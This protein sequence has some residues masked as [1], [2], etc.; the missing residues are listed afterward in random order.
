MQTP[1]KLDVQMRNVGKRATHLLRRRKMVPAI[2]YGHIPNHPIALEERLLIKYSD[3]K[4]ENM[5]FHL[6]CSTNSELHNIPVLIKSTER[7]PVTRKPLHLDFY[8]PD[9]TKD[10]CVTVKLKFV[11]KA[12][13]EVEGGILDIM[14]RDLELFCLPDHIPQHIEV[15][16]SPLKIGDIYHISHLHFPKG[17]KFAS[18]VD[19]PICAVKNPKG[20]ITETTEAKTSDATQPKDTP[21]TQKSN[22][23]PPDKK[24][25]KK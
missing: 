12:I 23:K 13:G 22:E 19:L 21:A 14:Q 15:D 8:A 10:I 5:I 2:V 20:G 1:I 18:S 24:T 25:T 9:M 3:K 4:F 16:I 7:D 6:Q 11:G 17:V